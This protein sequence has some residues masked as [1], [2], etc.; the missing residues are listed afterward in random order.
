MEEKEEILIELRKKIKKQIS[1]L[2]LKLI[3]IQENLIDTK[4]SLTNLQA[5]FIQIDENIENNI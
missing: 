1:D 2:E 5:F 4:N 3:V